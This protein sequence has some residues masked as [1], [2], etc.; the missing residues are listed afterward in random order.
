LVNSNLTASSSVE[1][2]RI[3][4]SVGRWRSDC[5]RRSAP[6]QAVKR[7]RTLS[8][9]HAATARIIESID[10]SGF[11]QGLEASLGSYA[12]IVP[13]P[14]RQEGGHPVVPTP[15]YGDGRFG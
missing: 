14:L 9:A 7:C 5:R 1:L 6:A 8:K 13:K 15:P 3:G 10:G 2:V 11:V 4:R 12:E